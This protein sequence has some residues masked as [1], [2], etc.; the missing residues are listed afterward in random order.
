MSDVPEPPF[1]DAGPRPDRLDSWKEI[2][3]YLRRGVST[4]QRWE[5]EEGLPVRRHVHN[6]LATVYAFKAEVDGWWQS[7]GRDLES[8]QA[9][10]T[11][12]EPTSAG[13]VP[14]RPPANSRSWLRWLAVVLPL[15]CLA[16]FVAWSVQHRGAIGG[17]PPGLRSLAVLPLK[18]LTG[19]PGFD[20]VA[21][22]LTDVLGTT[23]SQLGALTVVSSTSTARYKSTT[24]SAHEIADELGV[25]ALIE[26]AVLQAGA[27]LRITVAVVDAA[28]ERRLWAATYERESGD[29]LGVSG[30]VAR[31]VVRA[32][33]AKP[34][35]IGQDRLARARAVHP[36]AYEAYLRGVYFRDR[37]HMGGCVMAEPY[38]LQ[39]IAA[40]ADFAQP[41]AALAFC[42]GFDRLG[43]QMPAADAVARARQEVERALQIDADLADAHVSL[44]LIAHR[45]EYDWAAAE[46]GFKR[47]LELEPNHRDALTFYGELLYASGRDGQG[48]SMMRS[49]VALDP[50][51]LGRSTGLGYALYNLGRSQEAIDQLRRTVELDPSWWTARMWLAESYASAGLENKALDEYALLLRQVLVPDRIPAAAFAFAAP[52]ARSGGR[53]FWRQELALAEEEMRS[54][55]TVWQAP[56]GRPRT[57]TYLMARRHARL[58]D[59]ARTLA[60]LESAYDQRSYLLTFLNLEPLFHGI[61]HSARFRE[62]VH[63]IGLRADGGVIGG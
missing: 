17:S 11:V 31:A 10:S 49:A 52:H 19:D 48:L 18:N 28:T 16:G 53:E 59:E 51:S 55:G 45:L 34:T 13:R 42:Y 21:D 44:A 25:D 54:P 3:A 8:P 20:W 46:H 29:L 39:A 1:P 2:A 36:R 50:F 61:R 60:A 56:N 32:V 62:L 23:F 15:A 24:R 58:G 6:K 47:A 41:H 43:G 40:D 57:A 35:R 26:G 38:L 27:H 22:S 30:D 9:S 7:R 4:V 37:R 5:H 33:G 12:S 14:R 63:R